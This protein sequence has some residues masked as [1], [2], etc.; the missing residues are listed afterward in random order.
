MR[1]A[2]GMSERESSQQ[3]RYGEEEMFSAENLSK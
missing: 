1:I 2:E 3:L